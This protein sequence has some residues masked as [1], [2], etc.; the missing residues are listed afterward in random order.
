M[1]NCLNS[2]Q[3]LLWQN[4]AWSKTFLIAIVTITVFLKM[5]SKDGVYNKCRI[6]AVSLGAVAGVPWLGGD[7]ETKFVKRLT[8]HYCR[9][10]QFGSPRTYNTHSIAQRPTVSQPGL[11]TANTFQFWSWY[12]HFYLTVLIAPNIARRP[13]RTTL[14]DMPKNRHFNPNKDKLLIKYAKR[15]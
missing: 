6:K 2:H 15:W 3:F 1:H 5:V 9:A 10:L 11:Y 7:F 14:T 8:W 4:S 13:T 12:F